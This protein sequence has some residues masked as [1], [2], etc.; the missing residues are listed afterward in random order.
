MLWLELAV[1]TKIW[2]NTSFLRRKIWQN[3]KVHSINQII[4]LVR[5]KNLAKDEVWEQNMLHRVVMEHPKSI[6]VREN[7]IF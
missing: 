1:K 7:N 4:F 3:P 5:P 6:E 2:Y